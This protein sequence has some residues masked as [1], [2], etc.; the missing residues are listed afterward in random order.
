[1]D[2]ARIERA[3]AEL[4][5]GAGEDLDR[6]GLVDTPARVANLYTLLLAGMTQD[7]V[8]LLQPTIDAA[9]AGRASTRRQ[10]VLLRDLQF[11]S[12]C[13]HHLLPF[14]GR[15]HVAYYPGDALA[16]LSQ[17]ARAIDALARRLQVQE[18]LT[19][20]LATALEEALAPDGVAVLVEA[21]HLCLTLRGVSG[22]ASRL[23]TSSFR[24]RLADP[25]ER[26]AFFATL[27]RQP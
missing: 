20:Q 11:Y 24:G 17:V 7:P 8:A 13:E 3:V 12:L 25:T 14:F 10:L 18:R 26:A 21:E 2:Q 9:E 23:V 4:L 22:P 19:E 27:G 16:G 5:A 6:A 1:M 15:V